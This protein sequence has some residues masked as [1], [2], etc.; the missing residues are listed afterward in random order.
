MEH[1]IYVDNTNKVREN[2]QNDVGDL[3]TTV[4][5]HTTS[6]NSLTSTVNGHTTTLNNISTYKTLAT[7]TKNLANNTNV[8]FGSITFPANSRWIIQG[9]IGFPKGAANNSTGFVTI[10]NGTSTTSRP[11][12]SQTCQIDTYTSHVANVVSIRSFPEET[13]LNLVGWQNTGSTLNSCT[14]YM[15]GMRI[16]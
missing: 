4:S 15:I 9:G 11:Y 12:E 6:I 14:G 16:K 2:L 1:N 5:G 10:T 8:V 13:T 7:T 3:S